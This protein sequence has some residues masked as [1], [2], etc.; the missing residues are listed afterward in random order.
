MLV[1]EYRPP[2]IRGITSGNLMSNIVIIVNNTL[3]YLKVAKRDLK[4]S[5]HKKEMIINET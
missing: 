3:I 5:H 4:C 2:T 1:K